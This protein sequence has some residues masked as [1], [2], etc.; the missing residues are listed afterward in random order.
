ML[1]ARQE[2]KSGQ[3]YVFQH[4]PGA[5]VTENAEGLLL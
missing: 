1:I 5:D 3:G 2:L 4:S